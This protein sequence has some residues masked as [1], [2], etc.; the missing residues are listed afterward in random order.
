MRGWWLL[1]FKNSSILNKRDQMVTLID[2][3]VA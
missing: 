1:L 2:S 3:S